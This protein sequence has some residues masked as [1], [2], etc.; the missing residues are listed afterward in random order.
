MIEN[1]LYKYTEHISKPGIIKVELKT[2]SLQDARSFMK[3]RL[4]YVPSVKNEVIFIITDKSIIEKEISEM[5][6]SLPIKIPFNSKLP[7]NVE[8]IRSFIHES[9]VYKNYLQLEDFSG[10]MC[11][12]EEKDIKNVS[13]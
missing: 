13:N 11:F 3:H 4:Q 1:N 7:D 9:E 6:N 8:I 2:N 12:V 10:S 5:Y